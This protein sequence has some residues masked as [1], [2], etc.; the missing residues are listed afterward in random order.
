MGT[1]LHALQSTYNQ[2]FELFLI[3]RPT[4]II[5]CFYKLIPYFFGGVKK[6]RWLGWRCFKSSLVEILRIIDSKQTLCL[7]YLWVEIYVKYGRKTLS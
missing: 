5:I 4:L 1:V 3:L 7:C 6:H 2:T